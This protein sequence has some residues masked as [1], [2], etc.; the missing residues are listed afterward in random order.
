[1]STLEV[2]LLIVMTVIPVLGNVVA[3]ILRRTG[4][5]SSAVL[6]EALTPMAVT[7]VRSVGEVVK[8]K[9]KPLV[10][11][12]VL[13]LVLVGC[14]SLDSIGKVAKVA[15]ASAKL[16]AMA[17]PC[18]VASLERAREECEKASSASEAATCSAKIGHLEEVLAEVRKVR[19]E[20]MPDTCEASK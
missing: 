16:I 8:P 2:V 5:E 17:E 12:P 3:L 6:V 19:C 13:A 20:A 18:A 15:E 1:M 7:G 9:V 11:L 14:L 10:V 4:R